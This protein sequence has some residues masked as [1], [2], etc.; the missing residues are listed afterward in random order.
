M[1]VPQHAEY[2]EQAFAV[3]SVLN[4]KG[5]DGA[6][7]GL[8]ELPVLRDVGWFFVHI[9]AV[10]DE[11]AKLK[12]F[13]HADWKAQRQNTRVKFWKILRCEGESAKRVRVKPVRHS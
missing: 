5:I 9:R 1:H 6:F 2:P 8:A 11:I 7:Q 10:V 3:L 13:G 4:A 12:H